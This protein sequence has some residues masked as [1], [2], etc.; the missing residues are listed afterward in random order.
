M[1]IIYMYY[2]VDYKNVVMLN[3]WLANKKKRLI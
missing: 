1:L 3:N 2:C